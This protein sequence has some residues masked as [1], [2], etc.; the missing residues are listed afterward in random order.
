MPKLEQIRLERELNDIDGQ[1]NA[2]AQR[3]KSLDA[4]LE[5]ARKESQSQHDRFKSLALG[6]MNDVET[7]IAGLSER[8]KSI[9]DRVDRS[10]L[11]APV[12]GIVNAIAI[13]TIGG[14]IEPAKKLVEIV[15]IGSSLKIIAQVDPQQVAFLR[16]D[17]AARVKITAY[18]S[19]KYGSLEGVLARVAANSQTDPEGKPFFEIEV[20]TH[21]TFMGTADAPLPITPGMVA[22]VEIITGKRT[23]LDYLLKPFFQA[24]ERALTER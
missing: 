17:L 24:R 19:H 13:K 18:D 14:V 11:R 4:D 5:V 3:L 10:E 23:V 15:P 22:Q 6:E 21:D 9:G 8:I 1:M 7:E 16:K 20:Q 12:A 2:N